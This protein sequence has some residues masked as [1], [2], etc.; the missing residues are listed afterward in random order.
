MS[1]WLAK[2]S[3]SL[4]QENTETPQPFVLTCECGLEHNGLRR[5]RHQRIICKTC[6]ASLF[7][8][9][10]DV[11]PAPVAR[12]PKKKKKKGKGHSRG[13]RK[14]ATVSQRVVRS[15]ASVPAVAADSLRTLGLKLLQSLR[16]TVTSWLTAFRN[17]WTPF[18]LI[19]LGI[20]IMIGFTLTMVAR[21]RGLEAA[22]ETVRTAVE[23]GTSALDDGEL[24][25][26]RDHFAQAAAALDRLGRDDPEAEQI[27]QRWRETTAMTRLLSQ[28]LYALIEE[29]DHAAAAG[30]ED[31]WE[32]EFQA[33]HSGKWIVL[34]LPVMH[35][36]DKDTYRMPYPM[37]VGIEGRVVTIDVNVPVMARLTFGDAPRTVIMAAPVE[38]CSLTDNRRIWTLRLDTDQA[39]LWAHL[40]TYEAVGFDFDDWQPR[41]RVRQ[42]L[43]SQAEAV[44]ALSPTSEQL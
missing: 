37:P 6:G 2:A 41:A 3:S 27:R 31:E 36:A 13:R 26:A 44:G 21:S 23:A 15:V 24:A 29:G 19:I 14:A 9:P 8:L 10:K 43:E 38:S 25:E 18:R 11:Y 39:F 5:N 22:R 20:V 32:E 17:F 7:V 33:R 42:I 30:I 12:K 34:E 35:D 16:Q 40:D 1:G 28:D 4:R